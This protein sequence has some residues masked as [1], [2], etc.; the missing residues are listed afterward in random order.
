[1]LGLRQT[2]SMNCPFRANLARSKW[3]SKGHSALEKRR[4]MWPQMVRIIQPG[5]ALVA[6]CRL[7]FSPHSHLVGRLVPSGWEQSRVIAVLSPV[8]LHS[9]L[10]MCG[11]NEKK[12][13]L[14]YRWHGELTASV[15]TVLG[16]VEV[17]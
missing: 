10:D 4:S 2:A 5:F 8:R 7:D 11:G 16:S 12:A 17:V 6:G 3:R 9:S 14:P 1:M 13:L 15:Q